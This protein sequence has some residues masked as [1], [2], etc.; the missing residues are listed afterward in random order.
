MTLEVIFENANKMKP[1]DRCA[2][3]L[4]CGGDHHPTGR[5]ATNANRWRA[6][7]A[8]LLSLLDCFYLYRHRDEPA[9]RLT[10]KWI[11]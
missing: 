6:S 7:A 5:A 9:F 3:W 1:T 11:R 8:V 4:A 2:A 10:W